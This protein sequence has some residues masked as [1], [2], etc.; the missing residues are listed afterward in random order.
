M[1]FSSRVQEATLHLVIL[2]SSIP[3]IYEFLRLCFWR[4]WKFWRVLL[5]YFIAIP[6]LGHIWCFTMVRGRPRRAIPHSFLPWGPRLRQALQGTQ[7]CMMD[8][9]PWR[10]FLPGEN[11]KCMDAITK[12]DYGALYHSQSNLTCSHGFQHH[13]C[14]QPSIPYL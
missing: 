7:D 10:S 9:L 5:K 4:L 12:Y 6:Q 1:S 8:M 13:L 11:R 14:G 3:P 2:S